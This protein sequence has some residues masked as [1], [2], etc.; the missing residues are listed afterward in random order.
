MKKPGFFKLLKDIREY[1][2]EGLN[3]Q[4]RLFL[5][6]LLFLVTVMSGLLLIL[7][8]TGIFRV[9]FNE[10]Q[11]FLKNELNHIEANVEREFGSISMQGVSLSNMLTAEIERKLAEIDLNPASL[12]DSP[13]S[14]EPILDDCLKILSA[15]LNNRT[16][17]AFVI[18]DATVNPALDQAESSRSGLFLK[19]MLPNT[20]YVSPSSVR[21]LRGPASLA[22]E[23][24]IYL[25]PQWQMEFTVLPGDL[26]HLTMDAAKHGD[27]D[28]TKLYLWHPKSRSA[29][30]ISEGMLL[31]LP[32][33]ASDGTIMGICGFEVSDML[34]KMLYTP[35]NTVFGRIFSILAPVEQEMLDAS[36]ALLAGSY[37]VTSAGIDG[38]LEINNDIN[39]LTH[40]TGKEDVTYSGLCQTVNLYPKDTIHSDQV[41]RLGVVMPWQD[42]S[43]YM[44]AKNL[45]ILFLLVGLLITSALIALLLSRKY[46]RPVVNAIGNIRN[47]TCTDYEKTNIQEIDDLINFLAEQETNTA[48]SQSALDDSHRSFTLFET[49]VE[50]IKTLSP[51]ER[52]VFNLYME[53][54]NAR[55]I[56]EKL[57]LSINTIKT[58]NKRIYMKLN[59]SSRKELLVYVNMM[60]ERNGTLPSVR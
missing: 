32:V 38:P 49:F 58:H 1:S 50:N 3:L 34:F 24:S 44:M 31:S 11:I 33:I 21:C 10:S 48:L 4:R 17:A 53:G 14:L 22:R 18:L 39:G 35:D 13:S 25:S 46:I 55:E 37:T 27:T 36:K 30:D 23:N 40:L 15:S 7:F 19:N 9:G 43:D 45:R 51:A 5:F 56:A 41:W 28:L 47:K 42:L 60:K 12:Q 59:V 2:Y 6:F 29:A 16:S 8:A 54:Y 20:G 52:L 57:Y 26:F